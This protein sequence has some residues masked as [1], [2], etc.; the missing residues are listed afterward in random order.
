MRNSPQ[1]AEMVNLMDLD[2]HPHDFSPREQPTDLALPEISK[3]E[4]V[5]VSVETPSEPKYKIPLDFEKY[6]D[7]LIQKG[8]AVRSLRFDFDI[9]KSKE[10]LLKKLARYKALDSI[11]DDEYAQALSRLGESPSSVVE[12]R[13]ENTRTKSEKVISQEAP[14]EESAFSSLKVARDEYALAEAEWQKNLLRRQKMFAKTIASLA[15]EREAPEIEEPR[16]LVLARSEYEKARGA[17]VS[18]QV[19]SDAGFLEHEWLLEELSLFQNK[20]SEYL[21][22]MTKRIFTKALGNFD[23]MDKNTRAKSSEKILMGDFAKKKEKTEFAGYRT[24]PVRMVDSN[25]IPIRRSLSHVSRVSDGVERRSVVSHETEESVSL[26]PVEVSFVNESFGKGLDRLKQQI[27]DSY[28]KDIPKFIQLHVLDKA[29]EEIA[30]EF[31][32]R[33]EDVLDSSKLVLDEN[34]NLV[35]TDKD[36]SRSVLVVDKR[37]PVQKVLESKQV[38]ENVGENFAPETEKDSHPER[39]EMDTAEEGVGT[40]TLAMPFEE[41]NIQ[42]VRGEGGDL[43]KIKVLYNGVEMAEGI[44]LPNGADLHL[45]KTKEVRGGLLFTTVYERAF[46]H[47]KPFLKTLKTA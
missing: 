12:V 30:K 40:T 36:G 21:G 18:S 24:V 43:N 17:F 33:V 35:Y 8:R 42:V 5:Q 22:E 47:L 4:E 41:G 15:P 11:S 3:K 46:K 31:S 13:E 26:Y 34:G 6:I 27:L 37:V 45:L 28:K 9:V 23:G 38:F 29:N 16:E 20:K 25:T 44:A 32:V 10:D 7:E 2:L 19:Q 14:Q 39:L 1:R